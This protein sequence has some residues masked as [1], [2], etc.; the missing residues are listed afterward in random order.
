MAR[1]RAGVL[2]VD[3][4][5]FIK[6][7]QVQDYCKKAV[8]VKEVVAEIKDLQTQQSLQVLPYELELKEP[9]HVSI[10]HGEG[11]CTQ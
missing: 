1:G 3:S 9:S 10:A 6:R 2:V 11:V 8:T 5:A 7:Y 4:V